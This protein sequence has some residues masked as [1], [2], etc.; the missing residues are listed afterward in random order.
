MDKGFSPSGVIY[1]MDGLLLDT[2]PFYTLV[3]QQIAQRYGKN[4]DWSLKSKILGRRALE[5]ARMIVETLE[6]PLSAE[7]YLE[8]RNEIL[9]DMFSDSQPLPGVMKL[10]RH[11]AEAGIP[12]AVATSSKREMLEAKIANH[13]EWFSLFKTIVTGDDPEVK[14]G[15]PAPDIFLVAAKRVGADPKKCLAFEDAPTGTVAA[16][17][18]GMAVIAIPDENMDKKLYPEASKILDS[19]EE[20]LPELWGF[21]AYN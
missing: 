11:L 2:E 17:A 21:P 4:F 15:K 14:E 20:F 16:H 3:T 18:A 19:M 10:T 1:D 7:E 12:Q 13:Q 6:L 9:L 5:S 8:Q